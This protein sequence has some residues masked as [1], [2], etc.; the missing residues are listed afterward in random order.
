MTGYYGW[1]GAIGGIGMLLG[2]LVWLDV[3]VLLV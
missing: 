1:L 3:V 2:M